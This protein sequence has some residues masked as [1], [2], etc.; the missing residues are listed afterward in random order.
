MNFIIFNLLFYNKFILI[1]MTYKIY[2]NCYKSIDKNKY[3]FGFDLDNTLIKFNLKINTFELLYENIIVKLKKIMKLYNIVI[4]TNQAYNKYN[5][6]EEKITKLLELFTKNNI[7]IYIYVSTKNDNYRKPNIGLINII[8][9]DYCNKL[10]YYCGDA[11][12]R[13]GDFSD[14]D[15]K[16]AL[17]L[18]IPIFTPEQIFCNSKNKTIF[19]IMYP[20]L[21]KIKYN[22]NYIPN[23]KE[24]IIMIGYPASGSKKYIKLYQKQSF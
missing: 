1:I 3:I 17:N 13:K 24:M 5:L 9:K 10:K 7:Y 21:N 16:F 4:I 2:N 23:K 15:Y 18:N 19:N 11:C 22:F 8:E 12:G 6:F 14:T 20:E